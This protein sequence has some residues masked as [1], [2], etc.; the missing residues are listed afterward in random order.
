MGGAAMSGILI[1]GTRYEPA[2]LGLVEKGR[3]LADERGMPVTAVCFC[4]SLTDGEAGLLKAG[5][6]DRIIHIAMDPEDLNMEQTAIEIL[7][8]HIRQTSPAAVLFLN[9]VFLGVVAPGTAATLRCGL[10]ADCTG[11][12]WS[13]AGDLLQTRPTF[14]GKKLATIKSS[15]SPA[16]ASVRKGVFAPT[17]SSAA[18]P[19][20][21]ERVEAAP[22]NPMWMRQKVLEVIGTEDLSDAKLIL[23]GGLGIGSRENFEKL[24]KIAGAVGASVGASRAAVAAG[25]APYQYQIG[26]T[27]VTVQPE[28][29]CAFGIS[30]AVQHLSGIMGAKRIYA[31]NRDPNA[32]I[33]AYSDY[34]LVADCESVLDSLIE[35]L[36]VKD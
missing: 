11:L 35:L 10:T 7:A 15:G 19:C 17:V 20:D 3:T 4:P 34:S 33:H 22:Q 9:C 23:A 14:G 25:Y 31:V 16:M 32:P 29:Y 26:Q 36:F 2:L 30:G 5:G 12:E 27:G 6:A 8:E 13:E 21:I 1:A 24:K 18:A 28:L